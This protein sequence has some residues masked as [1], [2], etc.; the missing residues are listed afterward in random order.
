MYISENKIKNHLPWV[1]GF[2]LKNVIII[3]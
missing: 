1:D 2:L 3:R